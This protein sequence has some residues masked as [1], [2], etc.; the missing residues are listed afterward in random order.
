MDD[1]EL[2]LAAELKSSALLFGMAL[3]CTVGTAV[4]SRLAVGLLS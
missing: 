4:L 2:S 1:D 3:V